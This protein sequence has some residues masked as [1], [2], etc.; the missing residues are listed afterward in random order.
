MCSRIPLGTVQAA[1]LPE[2]ELNVGMEIRGKSTGDGYEYSEFGDGTI[3][4]TGYRGSAMVLVIY[5]FTLRQKI[6]AFHISF[7]LLFVCF[8]TSN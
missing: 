3:T 1:E 7:L 4:I 6:R 5:S 2:E 8:F